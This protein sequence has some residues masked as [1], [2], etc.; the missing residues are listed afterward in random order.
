VKLD[1]MNALYLAQ[2]RDMHSAEEQLIEALPKMAKAAASPELARA[3]QTHLTET[4][5]HLDRLS[6]ILQTLGEK[7]AGEKCEAM[8]GLIKE[9]KEVIDAKGDDRVRDAALIVCA[10]KVEHYEIGSYGSLCTHAKMMG[11]SEDQRLLGDTLEEEKHA[12]ELLTTIAESH[13]NAEAA[14]AR[15]RGPPPGF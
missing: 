1:S 14:R 6:R 4:K 15:P 5:S 10:Q 13:L 3:F 9:G 12:D 2:L 11:R 8:E 7:P